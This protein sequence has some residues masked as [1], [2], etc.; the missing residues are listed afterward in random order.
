MLE[1]Q[2]LTVC[3]MYLRQAAT[4]ESCSGEQGS[5]EAAQQTDECVPLLLSCILCRWTTAATEKSPCSQEDE[6]ITVHL[7]KCALVSP[8]VV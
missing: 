8:L 1:L 6:L 5:R 3:V 2:M 7:R 4:T